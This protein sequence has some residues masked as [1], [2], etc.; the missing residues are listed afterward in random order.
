MGDAQSAQRED[1]RDAAAEEESGKVDDA[2]AEENIE[3]KPL[4]NNGQI[5]EISGKADGSIAEVN[6]HCEDKIAAE[7][8]LS[9]DEDVSE[10]EKPL[11]EEEEEETPLENVEINEKESPNEA[12]DNEDAEIIEMDAKQNDI[13]EGFKRFFSNIGLKLTVKRGSETAK[14]VQDETNKEEPN[15]AEDVEDAAKDTKSENAEENTDVNIA[16]ETYDNDSTT[17][18]TLTDAT[19]EDIQNAEEEKTTE[20]QEKAESDNAEE[21]A[22]TPPPV[23]DAH[24]DAT[25]EEEPHSTSPSS[26]EEEVVVSPIKRFF[27][28]GIFSGLRKKKKAAEDETADKELVDMGKKEVIETTEQAAQDQQQNEE[29][30]SPEDKENEL[31]EEIQSASGQITDE[32]KSSSTDPSTIIINEPGILS[33]QEKEKVQASPLKRLLSGSK[34]R[35]KKQ[36]SRR[37][38]DAKLSDSGEHVQDQMPSAESPENQK[39]EGPTQPSADAAGEEDSAW[40]SFKKLMTPKKLLKRSSL[41]NEETQIAVPAEEPKANEGEQVSDHSTEEGKK[42]KDSSVS[43]EA[44]L[45]GSGRRRSR[46]TSDSED[47]TPQADNEGGSKHAAESPLESSNENEIVASSPKQ[48]GSPSEGD[49]GST[50]KSLKKLVTPKRKAKDEDESKDNIQSDSEVTQDESSFSIKKL[51][52]G[53]K[54]RKSVEKQ[55]QVSS[56]EADK[57]VVSVEEDSETPAVVPLSEFDT[58]DAEVHIQTQADIESHIPEEENHELQKDLLDQMAEPVPP[59][60]SLQMESEEVQD[61][62]ALEEQASAAPATDEE[63]DDLTES[64]SKHQQLSD[65]PE[66]GIISETMVTPASFNEEAARDDTIAEDLIEIT[67]EAITA[68][69]PASDITLPDETEMISAVSQLSS[70]SSKTSG[71]TTPVPAEYD[72]METDTLL[73]QVVETISITPESV[74]VFSDEQINERIAGTVSHQILE[75]F[76]EEQP[77][78]LEA[79]RRSDATAIRTG[80]NAEELDTINAL[81]ATPQTESISEVNDSVST[82]IVSEV[83]TEEFDT[84][85][86]AVDEV[87]EVTCSEEDIKEL[88][89]LSEAVTTDIPEVEETVPGT[90]SLVEAHHAETEPPKTDSQEADTAATLTIE[91]MSAA[92]TV[93]SE[94]KEEMVP[95]TEV[96]VEPEKEDE[97]E[98]EA[99]KTEDDQLPE[100]SEAV[101]ASTLDS[102]ESSGQSP[103]EEVISEDTSPAETVTDE[104]KETAEH[105]QEPEVLEAVQA[106]TIDTEVDSVQS[107][108]KEVMSEDVPEEGTVIDEPKEET[109]PLNEVSLEPVDASKTEDVQVPEESE[110]VEASTLD[111]EESSVQSPKEDVISE[112]I[113]PAE[114]VTEEPKETAEHVQEPEVIEAVQEPTI[115]S[116]EGNVQSVEKEVI[117]DDVPEE[118]TVTDEPKEETI[119]EVSLEPVD[120]SKTEDVQISE[121]SEAVQ[122]STL[123]SEESSVQSPKDDVQSEDIP[124][125]ETDKDE[126]KQTAEDVEEPEVTEAAQAPTIDSEEGKETVKLEDI[127]PAETAT[128]EPKQTA[129]DVQ[130]PEVIEAA[131]APKVDSEEEKDTVKSEDIAPAETATDEP[132]QTAEHV[133]EPEVIEAAQAPTVDSEEG[134][135]T[136]KSEDIATAETATDEP[137]QTAEHVQEPEVI[138][139]V[140]A[141]TVDSEEGKDTV[142]SEDTAPADEPKQTAE[143]LTEVSA[144]TENNQLPVNSVKTEQ[145]QESEVLE[146]FPAPTL[147][148]E[149]GSVQSL[150]KETRPEGIPAVETITAEP[151]KEDE[152]VEAAE[153]DIQESKVLPSDELNTETKT[154]EEVPMQV[155]TESTEGGSA[156][157][158][159][160]KPDNSNASALVTD[161]TASEVVAQLVHEITEDQKSESSP[162]DVT[163]KQEDCI[164]EVAD[165]LPALTAVHVCSVNEE[166]SIVTDLGKAVLS[167]ETSAPCLDNAA[168]TEEPEL[169]L[170][171]VEVNEEQEKEGVLPGTEINSATAEHAVVAQVVVCNIKDVPVAIPDV[172]IEKTSDVTEPL[173]DTM[174]S[175]L[176]FEEEVEAAAPLVRNDVAQTAKEGSVVTMMH[177]PS[178]TFED[179][180]R[181][182]VQEVDV[183]IKST[184]TIVDSVLEVGVTESKEVIDVCHET[185]EKVDNLSATPETEKELLHEENKVNVQ[186]VIQHVK[187]NLPETVSES[188]PEQEVIIQPDAVTEETETE[189]STA[190]AVITAESANERQ[191]SEEN[192]PETVPENLE[193][194]VIKESDAV[195]KETETEDSIGETLREEQDEAPAVITDDSAN[196]RQV[197]EENLPETVSESVPENLEQEVIKESDAVTKETEM[198]DSIGETLRKK[199]DEAPAGITDDSAKDRQ[200]SEELIQATDIAEGLDVS[201]HDHKVDVEETKTEQEKPEGVTAEEVKPSETQ[202]AQI[203]PSPIV[204]ASNTG[205]VVPQ[206][207]GIISSIGNVESPSSLSLEFKLNIQFGQAKAPTSSPPPT[208]E[209]NAPVKQTDVSEVGVQAVE[210]VE[211]VNPTE[212]TNGL[213]KTELAEVSVQATETTESSVIMTQPVLLDVGVQAIEPVN[214]VEQIKSSETIT[215]S[216]QATETREPA[217]NL[218]LTERALILTEPLQLDVGSQAMETVEPVEQIKPTERVT[219]TV[220]A[221][222]ATQVRPAEKRELLLSQPVLFEA[223]D[224]ET[225]A[226]QPVKQT[227]EESE[228]DVWMDA[229]EVIYTQ[230]ETE[231]SFVEAEEPQEPQTASEPEE[232]AGPEVETA[233][234]SKTEAEESHQEMHKTGGTCEIESEAE[235]FAVAPEYQEV[236]GA[237]VSKMEWD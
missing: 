33:S 173:I 174:A 66:E 89:S 3:A 30:T 122:A 67:S 6:G 25:A 141:P 43:W 156:Q 157:E 28:T 229:E 142:K 14:N 204:T 60:D 15:T 214:T 92:E 5:S 99:A 149:G 79:H 109:I 91:D 169:Q 150:E 187:E 180:H 35:P 233:P 213:K 221:T 97:L 23:E 73:N 9:P 102:E 196:E 189:D 116:E 137:K 179:N 235:D 107:V 182:Q 88:E 146:A 224:Q 54:K 134:K 234:D 101:E 226:E 95:L 160:P 193:Q 181:I 48:A 4:I 120:A 184:E 222:E 123:D 175:Q 188:V 163:V 2:P 151:Q 199:Q 138:E 38:S 45:C 83:P 31:K 22:T 84:A 227:E 176:A 218:D 194:E 49:G 114:T 85:E 51:L 94:L 133:Q 192:L 52:P 231:Q 177:V 206:N 201:I 165:E 8:N 112:D 18:P 118:G 46:K 126:P 63:P 200:V 128:D 82:E 209:R 93:T 96:N 86:I 129:E 37:S 172:L 124:Q 105:V 104:P 39:E 19:S 223:C 148:L 42:R 191:V 50:W 205:L 127:A 136:V 44:V 16:Q 232:Q 78:I 65:I 75:T 155:V 32:G 72:V 29:E 13:N 236:S 36:R 106:P 185:V 143:H 219:S 152:P 159:I 130:E 20:S 56:D 207:T 197:S 55:D 183:D 140:R 212:I 117:S 167:G 215:S 11:Q 211:P 154:V 131:Q 171:S 216:V 34:K 190:P 77:T 47:E 162:Q 217:E 10:T 81:T 203:V 68:P 103:K 24:H 7:A 125:T 161:E 119:L 70:E 170:S 210:E 26:P 57:D 166:T 147:H 87:Y 12:D 121:T 80:L 186:E 115:D 195:T 135:D 220:Q 58:A 198:E 1:K 27:T 100:E 64:I 145:D 69:E 74:P 110:A 21:A 90:G 228:Q 158:D 230:E 208:T 202:I 139:A 132:K 53:R 225:K 178:V 61:N 144:E 71:N 62:D 17:C 98:T 40:A 59:C 76:V 237:S 113:P 168:V 111:S 164:P 41:S 108:E 153:T